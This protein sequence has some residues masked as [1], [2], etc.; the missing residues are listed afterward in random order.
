MRWTHEV[1][2]KRY[3]ILQSH[4]RITGAGCLWYES[5]NTATK[6]N[7]FTGQSTRLP[8]L[9]RILFDLGCTMFKN[10]VYIS[11]GYSQANTCGYSGTRAEVYRFDG[12]AW[13]QQPSLLKSRRYHAM[14][15]L[16]NTIHV[17]GGYH[18]VTSNHKL[19][20]DEP[21]D[22]VEKLAGNHWVEVK[23]D[24][25]TKFKISGAVVIN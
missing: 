16:D 15:V 5:V 2:N 20:S 12:Q 4:L 25:Q 14:V 6:Y 22:T 17:L 13:T 7:I 3:S 10:Y 21:L 9:P 8:P 1:V 24:L 11:G 23:P 18:S 19:T